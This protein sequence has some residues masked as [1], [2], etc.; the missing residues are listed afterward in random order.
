M[1]LFIDGEWNSYGGDLISLAIVSECGQEFYEVLNCKN[2]DPWVAENVIPKLNKEPISLDE[3]QNKLHEFL[4]QFDRIHV[5]ADWPEDISWLCKSLIRG[6]GERLDTPPLTLEV[7]RVD[8]VS[9]IPH[10]ALA[11]ARALRGCYRA[12]LADSNHLPSLPKPVIVASN[13]AHLFTSDQMRAYAHEAIEWR[14][15]TRRDPT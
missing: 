7:L 3:F 13:R 2:P 8:S 1:D 4:I 15:R 10:N 5:I 11:D 9:R 14:N 12:M 6:P